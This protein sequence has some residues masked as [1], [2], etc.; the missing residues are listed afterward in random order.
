MTRLNESFNS[1]VKPAL[2]SHFGYKNV[3]QVPKL[4]KIII[5]MGVGE[6]SQDKKKIESPLEEM[7]L[8][9]GQKPIITRARKSIAAFKLRDDMIVGCK[10]T[11]RG[12]RMY[13]FLDR[14]VN[15]ALPRVR[16]FRGI[17]PKSFDGRGNFALGIKEQIV[18]PEINY[19]KVDNIRG[20]DVIICTTAKTNEEGLE[21]L[22][23]FNMPF[24]N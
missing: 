4:E 10:V 23:G 9:S 1:E 17:S 6:A 12:N 5:N 22:K 15:I 20:M 24:T 3:M 8:I 7:A 14:L 11:L 2:M 18:F 19:D 16:D 21:L 13:E